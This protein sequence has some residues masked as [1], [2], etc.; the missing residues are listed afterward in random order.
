VVFRLLIYK[1]R[2]RDIIII[3]IGLKIVITGSEVIAGFI[4]IISGRII[5]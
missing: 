1:T 5:A 3:I 2:L 4:L